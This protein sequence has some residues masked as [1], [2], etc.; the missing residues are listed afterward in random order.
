MTPKQKDD[1]A[2]LFSSQDQ[3]ARWSA[4]AE[5][6]AARLEIARINKHCAYLISQPEPVASLGLDRERLRLVLDYIRHGDLN[7]LTRNFED[8][9]VDQ[10]RKEV[11]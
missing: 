6:A 9:R 7:R 8:L 5:N 3:E 2:V 10:A 4:E 11:K 1:L